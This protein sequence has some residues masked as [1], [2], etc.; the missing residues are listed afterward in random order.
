MPLPPTVF[1]PPFNI[2][3]A[4]H[5][6]LTVADLAASRDFYVEVLG[7]VVSAEDG[8][9]AYL[10][11]VEEACHHSLV[12]RR[13]S[14]PSC[15]RIGMRVVN[16][17]HLL[18]A[19]DTLAGMGCAVSW[20]SVP[21][22]GP[23]LH[24]TDPGG[25]PLEI[26]ARMDAMPRMITR[27]SRHH[28]GAAGRLDHYQLLI[29]EVRRACDFYMALGFRVTEYISPDMPDGEDG[30]LLGVFLQRKGNPHDIVFFN[31]A[32][33]RL[34][35]FAFTTPE[36]ASLLR[37]CDV[38][39]ELGH[40][41]RVER[42]PGRHGPGHAMF[43]YFRDPDGH[44]VELFNTHY[45]VM[46]LENEPVRWDPSDTNISFPWGLPAQRRWF[47]EATV[48]EGVPL[49]EPTSQPNPLHLERFL[50]ALAEN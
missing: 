9:A 13:G 19:H 45:Q 30:P 16:E 40:G 39:G 23:T 3:R 22:Q 47:E 33:P 34:H 8:E 32:G 25:V 42:G 43:V 15:A 41:R 49:A 37:A 36:A 50:A 12:L 31:G 21:F 46:D 4:S 38:A 24:V 7:L 2:T 28:G 29:P 17:D 27:F 26:C 10:R 18:R 14:R 1:D 35:H 5:V 44:R 11:G 6:V 48:F 20:A